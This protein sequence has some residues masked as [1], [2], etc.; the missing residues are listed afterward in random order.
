[1]RLTGVLILDDV[2]PE[3]IKKKPKRGWCV[4]DEA[5]KSVAEEH[6]DVFGCPSTMK[7][8]PEVFANCTSHAVMN[9]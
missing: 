4:R 5:W 8:F 9:I 1:M 2:A 3:D 6:F 7:A